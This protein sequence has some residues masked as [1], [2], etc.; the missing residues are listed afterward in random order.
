MQE[1]RGEGTAA[2]TAA[3]REPFQPRFVKP[4]QARGQQICW[5]FESPY[6]NYPRTGLRFPSPLMKCR[7]PW[8]A[9]GS[10]GLGAAAW[11]ST[12]VPARGSGTRQIPF[13]VGRRS[14]LH[15]DTLFAHRPGKLHG[16]CDPPCAVLHLH[17]LQP[18]GSSYCSSRG[19]W[20]VKWN[21]ADL[22]H[23]VPRAPGVRGALSPV[24][25]PA[26]TWTSARRATA[27]AS[28]PAST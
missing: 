17:P 9:R 19:L 7:R 13:S 21:A 24:P 6:N 2:A 11:P 10:L 20:D 23:A 28:R 26:Q 18:W 22:S 5:G 8:L 4:K 14:C 25:L 12:P 16:L 27:A 15:K 3:H 1:Q